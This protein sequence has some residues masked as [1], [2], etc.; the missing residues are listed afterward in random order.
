[1]SPTTI[2]LPDGTR[3]EIDDEARTVR[4]VFMDGTSCYGVASFTKEDRARAAALGYGVGT[5]AVWRMHREHDLAHHLVARALG[6]DHSMVLWLSAQGR[7]GFPV[8][9]YATEERMSFLVQ[10]AAQVGVEGCA[11]ADPTEKGGTS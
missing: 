1:M 3:Y 6:W 9:V 5:D 4:S 7:S 8:G 2:H 10:R 11:L